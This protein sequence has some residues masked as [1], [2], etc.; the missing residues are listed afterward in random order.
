M[1]ELTVALPMYKCSEVAWLALE[2]LC[3]Q[4]NIDFDWELL[5]AEEKNEAYGLKKIQNFVDRLKKNRCVRLEYISL[6]S[7][8]PLLKKWRLL[9]DKAS[10]SRCFLI[11]AAD[12]YSQPS[13]LKETYDLFSNDQT[14]WC[15][16]KKGAFYELSSEQAAIFDYDLVEP[17]DYYYKN[18][19]MP[20]TIHPCCLNMAIKTSLAKQIPRDNVFKSVDRYIFH[21]LEEYKQDKLNVVWNESKN[22]TMGIDT[23]GLNKISANRKYRIK[24]KIRPFSKEEY[25][26]EK[27]IPKKVL[28]KIKEFK[29]LV[30]KNQKIH[31]D[32]DIISGTE[33]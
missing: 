17:I 3:D 15:Q 12:C 23:D 32:L 22:W 30:T 11:Q 28:K 21:S 19:F 1:I 24:N 5:I 31:N 26:V 18:V 20:N 6:D 2:S 33:N 8:V 27:N 29:N 7:W 16:S 14:D 4:K 10:D 25:K 9:A 13:R